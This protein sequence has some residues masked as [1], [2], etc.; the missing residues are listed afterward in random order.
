MPKIDFY[1]SKP[2]VNAA[3]FLGFFPDVRSPID[4]SRLGAFITNP[5]SLK[6]RTPARGTRFLTFR[7]GFLLHTGYPNPGLNQVIRHHAVHWAGSS[8]PVIVHILAENADEVL[9]CTKRLEVIGG[10]AGIELGIADDAD[11]QMTWSMIQAAI[12]ELP[13]IVRL[14]M[15]HAVE[16]AKKIAHLAT[17]EFVTK[18][19][20]EQEDTNPA[21]SGIVAFSLGPTR[22]VLPDAN[23]GLQQGRLYGPAFYPLA[24]Q[25]IL[26]LVKVGIP[27]IG[28]GGIYTPGDV[29]AM[30]FAGAIAVQ[31]DAVL[32]GI[33][34]LKG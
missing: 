7:G 17:A 8:L 1:L 12:G 15:N 24:L 30:L 2:V 16:L 27:V 31:L 20:M 25:T 6:P 21:L 23:G 9:E 3:G 5:V 19:R 33:Q 28:A 14:P 34:T 11:P 4:F 22:G 29:D 26:S 18:N 32:W 13:V 10:V